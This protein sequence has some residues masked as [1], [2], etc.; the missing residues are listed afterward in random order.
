MA[1]TMR[2]VRMHGYGGPD[3]L[4]LDQVPRPE[5]G[6][7]QVLV[8]VQAA[9]VNPVDWKIREGMLKEIL[10][11]KLPSPAGNDLAGVVEAVG[12]GVGD[13][14][15]GSAVYAM[16]SL[17]DIGAYADFAVLDRAGVAAKPASLDFVTAAAVPMG[18]L[19]AWQA[20]MECGGLTAGQRV[21]G[22]GAGG[23][24]GGM[25]V[26]IALAMGAHVTA[27]AYAKSEAELR[28]WGVEAFIDYRAQPFESVARDFD[29]VFDTLGGE[30]QAKSWGVLKRGGVLVT[31]VGIADADAPERHGVRSAWVHA[32]PEGEQLRRVAELVDAG[33][34]R[35][36]VGRVLPLAE[37]GQAQELSRAGGTDG[38]VVLTMD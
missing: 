17:T 5:P 11:I 14:S 26:Q 1:E 36:K 25:A 22:H 7:G 6:A 2:A 9:S 13:L 21:L 35:V 10:P 8:R 20:L 30:T 18:A 3:Q 19:T 23:N 34:V 37:A 12:G 31:A 38:K 29:I 24:V 32:R 16:L 15:V 28:G 27:A 4:V 33:K